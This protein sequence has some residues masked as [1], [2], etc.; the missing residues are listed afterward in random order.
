MSN[1]NRH[2]A[3]LHDGRLVVRPPRVG[4]ERVEVGAVQAYDCAESEDESA[5]ALRTLNRRT[6]RL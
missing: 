3:R 6:Y 1:A 5:E 2:V 4:V